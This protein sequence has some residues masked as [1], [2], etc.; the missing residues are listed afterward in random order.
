MVQTEGAILAGIAAVFQGNAIAY[1]IIWVV[2]L[3]A[4]H[5]VDASYRGSDGSRFRLTFGGQAGGPSTNH[6]PRS[7]AVQPRKRKQPPAKP[8]SEVGVGSERT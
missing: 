5:R 3:L 4:H 2:Y 1:A 7:R 6:R 8:S